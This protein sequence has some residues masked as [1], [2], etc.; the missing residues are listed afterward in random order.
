MPELVVA[1]FNLHAGVDGW[2]RP[3]DVV[4]ACHELEADVLVLQETWTPEG[5]QG[6]ASL[7]AAA[8]DYE[9]HEARLSDALLFEPDP[10]AGAR[11]LGPVEARATKTRRPLWV[12]DAKTLHRVRSRRPGTKA[13]LGGWGIAVLSRFAVRRV[14]T[15][16]LGRLS[17]DSPRLRAA[18]FVEVDVD[19]TPLTVVG[20]HLAH[21]LHGSPI[22]LDRLRRRLPAA[23]EPAVLAGDMNF[24]GPPVSLALPRWRRAAHART[25]PSWRAHSQID[26]IFVTEPVKVLS[27]GSVPVGRSDHLPLRARLALA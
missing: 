26:H 9:V 3:F 24:W 1:T 4:T 18:L 16:E 14:E 25:Y 23:S 21:F 27:G 15:V 5:G 6:L 7:V 20:T 11:A 12:S 19:G 13:S 2:G 8:D 22:L 17:R 10:R